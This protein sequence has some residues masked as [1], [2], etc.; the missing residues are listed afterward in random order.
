MWEWQWTSCDSLPMHGVK[1][2]QRPR[3]R[4]VLATPCWVG[5]SFLPHGT[6]W[7]ALWAPLQA[8]VL[9]PTGTHSSEREA[10]QSCSSTPFR[11]RLMPYGL[12]T[13]KFCSRLPSPEYSISSLLMHSSSVRAVESEV[14][15]GWAGRQAG[16]S[17]RC[18][19]QV[20]RHASGRQSAVNVQAH[21][22]LQ[23]FPCR[24]STTTDGHTQA[25]SW[26]CAELT[27]ASE[28]HDP[29]GALQAWCM[30]LGSASCW[31]C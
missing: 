9:V 29:E 22:N 5:F 6:L 11:P 2:E 3:P 23:P 21:A 8:H 17:Q 16:H 1:C 28:E 25:L 31:S 7:L 19:T 14:R 13:S 10:P 30:C 27:Y 12:S 26:L 4:Q 15:G 18:R 20:A 24:L